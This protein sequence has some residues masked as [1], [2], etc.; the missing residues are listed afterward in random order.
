MRLFVVLSTWLVVA[1]IAL[2]PA[3]SAQD[4]PTW[5]LYGG[6]GLEMIGTQDGGRFTPGPTVQFGIVRQAP[7]SRFGARLD[8]TYY[9]RDRSY[10]LGYEG[11]ETTLGASVG[12]MYDLGTGGSRPY[13][14]GGVGMYEHSSPDGA[15]VARHSTGALIGGFGLRRAIGGAR[16]FGE[17]RYHYMTNGDVGP[18]KLFLTFGMRF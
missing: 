12:A 14:V 15:P 7:G 5:Q 13:V 17:L 6:L 16:V 3:V 11:N 18:H 4:L 10:V 1:A 8:A 2:V 9:Q